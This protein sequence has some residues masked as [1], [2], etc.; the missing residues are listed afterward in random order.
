[1]HRPNYAISYAALRLVAS[2]NVIIVIY[3]LCVITLL[4]YD[5]RPHINN[6]IHLCVSRYISISILIVFI[7]HL[8]I[9][10]TRFT[11]TTLC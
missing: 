4:T 11:H 7:V 5:R 3:L 10:N 1:M 8:S 9:I 2:N 6:G